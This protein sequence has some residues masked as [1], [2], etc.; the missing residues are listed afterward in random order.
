MALDP[1]E[2]DAAVLRNLAEKTG[3]GLEG[4]VQAL[5]AAGPFGKPGEAVSWL[6]AQGL[7]HVT[8]QVVVRQIR[9]A[10]AALT[11]EDVLGPTGADLFRAVER[12]L[13]PFVPGLKVG[14]RLGYVTLATRTQFAVAAKAKGSPGLWLGLTRQAAGAAL[15]PAPPMGGSGRFRLLLVLP[16]AAS[17]AEALP[18]LRAAAGG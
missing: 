7:G 12:A 6:K 17:I 16:E 18:H 1:E 11:V 3:R 5:Q 15:P 10:R 13:A 4:W 8:A 2:M 14:V 9:P